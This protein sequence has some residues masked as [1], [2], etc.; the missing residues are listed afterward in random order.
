M[1]RVEKKTTHIYIYNSITQLYLDVVW[2]LVRV[3]EW[4]LMT[5]ESKISIHRLQ[6]IYFTY[7]ECSSLEQLSSEGWFVVV[8]VVVIVPKWQ[9]N[10]MKTMCIWLI[11]S[12]SQCEC[13]PAIVFDAQY[14][15]VRVRIQYV[16]TIHRTNCVVEAFSMHNIVRM[17]V[18]WYRMNCMLE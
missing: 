5:K 15:V 14:Y 9:K 11:K 2:V 4:T 6:Y 18:E 3:F 1:S 17:N 8:V 10:E 16:N 7:N 12:R 13:S